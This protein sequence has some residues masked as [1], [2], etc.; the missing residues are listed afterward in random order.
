MI[1]DNESIWVCRGLNIIKSEI[2]KIERSL[3]SFIDVYHPKKAFIVYLKGKKGAA[4]INGCNIIYTDILD[5]QKQ[6]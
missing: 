6:L 3:R 2:G 4:K 5:I 1:R